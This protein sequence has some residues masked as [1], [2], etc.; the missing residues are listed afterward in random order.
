VTTTSKTVSETT[1]W[2]CHECGQVWNPARL[3]N[4]RAPAR[5]W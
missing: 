2:R 1:Y 3:V 4:G 5:R